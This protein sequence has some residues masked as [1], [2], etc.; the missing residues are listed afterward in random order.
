MW[1]RDVICTALDCHHKLIKVL[2]RHNALMMRCTCC[3]SYAVQLIYLDVAAQR[4]P[5]LRVTHH[6]ANGSVY[7][8][9]DFRAPAE[10]QRV[11]PVRAFETLAPVP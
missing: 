2:R 5:R 11:L 1:F 8:L 9:G 6:A 3:R 4:G 7:F 10:V